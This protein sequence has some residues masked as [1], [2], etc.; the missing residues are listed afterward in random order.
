MDVKFWS[1]ILSG[2][3]HTRDVVYRRFI[4]IYVIYEDFMTAWR[5]KGPSGKIL[6][7]TTVQL[8]VAEKA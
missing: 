1:K 4:S 6:R 5:R 2:I 7:P 8:V 3:Y